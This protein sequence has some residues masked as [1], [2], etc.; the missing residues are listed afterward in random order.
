MSH[1]S[2]HDRQCYTY[3]EFLFEKDADTEMFCGE[4]AVALFNIL[5]EKL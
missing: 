2:K 3:T 1:K 5:P 4:E